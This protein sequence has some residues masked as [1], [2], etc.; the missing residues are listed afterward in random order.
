[1]NL[2]RA[3]RSL[4]VEQWC[5]AAGAV[6]NLVWDDLHGYARKTYPSDIDV[7]FYDARGADARSE[8][9]INRKLSHCVPDVEW[10]AVNQA[11]I[12]LYNRDRP[13][14][15]IEDAISRWA[16]T[17]TA[18]GVSLTD[19]GQ[20]EIIAPF[21]LEDLFGLVVRPNLVTPEA[22]AVYLRRMTTKGWQERWPKLTI[23]WPDS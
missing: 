3:V 10:E 19:A 17:V 6:R 12:H 21:G 20:I 16:E 22:K 4:H 5:I 2:L 14:H 1:M 23:L 9:E 7:L 18:I 13:Y 11:T 15:S 8:A